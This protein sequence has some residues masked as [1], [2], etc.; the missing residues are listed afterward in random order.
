MLVVS[1]VGRVVGALLV[2]CAALYLLGTAR[3][4]QRAAH[5]YTRIALVK[6]RTR[7]LATRVD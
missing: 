1:R 5:T 2:L 7:Q 6:V 3:P 4:V